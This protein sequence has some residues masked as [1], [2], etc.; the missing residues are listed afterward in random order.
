VAI[1][2][3]IPTGCWAA[4]RAEKTEKQLD[5]AARFSGGDDAATIKKEARSGSSDVIRL[6][7]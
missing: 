1:E 5:F 7:V 2:A 6:A 4:L 3:S